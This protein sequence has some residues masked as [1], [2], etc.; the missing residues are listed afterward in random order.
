MN[1]GERIYDKLCATY[2]QQERD[3]FEELIG[4]PLERCLASWWLEEGQIRVDF[5]PLARQLHLKDGDSLGMILEAKW[6]KAKADVVRK[7]AT[8]VLTIGGA[9]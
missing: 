6:G 4:A 1:I 5:A 9:G 8:K 2:T 3:I 7:M